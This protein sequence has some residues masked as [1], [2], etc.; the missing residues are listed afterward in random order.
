MIT[1]SLGKSEI[2][3]ADTTLE[4]HANESNPAGVELPFL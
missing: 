4:R 3:F 2:R 1:L